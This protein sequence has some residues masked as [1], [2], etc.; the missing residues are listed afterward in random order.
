MLFW[1]GLLLL[2]LIDFC[3]NF[4]S[5]VG[6]AVPGDG[7]GE[8]RAAARREAAPSQQEEHQAQEEA[9]QD[10]MLLLLLFSPHHPAIQIQCSSNSGLLVVQLI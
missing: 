5:G 4:F 8:D 3:G 2:G 6:E 7:E 1:C 9:I 10:G